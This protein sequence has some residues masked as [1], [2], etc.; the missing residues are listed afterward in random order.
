MAVEVARILRALP[1]SG[2]ALL[3][4][5]GCEIETSGPEPTG[6]RA[7]IAK[8]VDAFQASPMRPEIEQRLSDIDA[9]SDWLGDA[10]LREGVRDEAPQLMDAFSRG[11]GAHERAALVQAAAPTVFA[12]ACR[13][14]YFSRY[15]LSKKACA[16]FQAPQSPR[17][18]P[19]ADV[20]QS[21][22]GAL[23]PLLHEH[24]RSGEE[25]LVDPIIRNTGGPGACIQLSLYA[26]GAAQRIEE[27][28]DRDLVPKIIR[29]AFNCVIGYWPGTGVLEIVVRNGTF[30]LRTAIAECFAQTALNASADAIMAIAAPTIALDGLLSRPLLGVDAED[31]LVSAKLVELEVR[32]MAPPGGVVTY[33]A[34]GRDGDVWEV[35]DANAKDPALLTMIATGAKIRVEYLREGG[36]RNFPL[37]FHLISPHRYTPCGAT[38]MERLII[39]KYLPRWG[40]MAA[41]QTPLWS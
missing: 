3:R 14:R 40:L 12:R 29:P 1:T 2:A 24:L 4:A 27:V 20:I 6:A 11:E 32:S 5:H 18:T 33:E 39:E 9:M 7:L 8:L 37:T 16:R 31:R 35:V 23:E 28:E 10:C 41:E 22:I 34:R 19:S 21:L 15:R 26:S 25:I 36:G 13:R 30:G 38:A 17:W